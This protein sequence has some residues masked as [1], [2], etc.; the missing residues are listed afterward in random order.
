MTFLNNNPLLIPLLFA[1]TSFIGTFA[2]ILAL[3]LPNKGFLTKQLPSLFDHL[4]ETAM[5]QPRKL[6]EELSPVIEEK[7]SDLLEDITAQIPMGSMLVS[8]SLG[9]TLKERAKTAILKMLPELKEKG[10]S[11]SEEWAMRKWN[12]HGFTLLLKYGTLAALFSGIM[13]GICGLIVWMLP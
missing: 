12:Q 5:L 4:G 2:T 7:I 11:K 8:G 10:L 6:E 1:F 3:F 9:K 13:G